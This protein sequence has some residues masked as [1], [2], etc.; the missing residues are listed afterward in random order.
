MNPLLSDLTK[1]S[2]SELDQK[3]KDLTKKYYML[4]RMGNVTM[5]RQ[6]FLIMDEHMGEKKRREMEILKSAERDN[7]DDINGLINIG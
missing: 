6:V 4:S 3:C 5:A 1:L 2:D 7:P